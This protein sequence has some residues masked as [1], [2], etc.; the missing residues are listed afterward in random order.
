M[1]T[2]Q[3]DIDGKKQET[4]LIVDDNESILRM[5]EDILSMY[6]FTTISTTSGAEAIEILKKNA[7]DIV[8]SDITMP[9][10]NGFELAKQIRANYP[11]IKIQ[12]VSGYADNTYN[13]DGVEDLYENILTKPF[14][15]TQLVD[16]IKELVE[17]K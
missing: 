12:L 5:N 1:N 6:G 14:D 17:S 2:M 11:N 3:Q 13:T 7:V 4:I 8:L 10:M 15:I 16:K 9:N